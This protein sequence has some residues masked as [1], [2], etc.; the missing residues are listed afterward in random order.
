LLKVKDI[1][2]VMDIGSFTV[3]SIS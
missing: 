1:V 2:T 3:W